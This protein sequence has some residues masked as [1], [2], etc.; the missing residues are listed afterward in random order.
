[1]WFAVVFWDRF[2]ATGVTSAAQVAS[3]RGIPAGGVPLFCDDGTVERTAGATVG[4]VGVVMVGVPVVGLVVVGVVV[5]PGGDV[6]EGD[7]DPAFLISA[8]AAEVAHLRPQAFVASTDIWI[9]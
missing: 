1:V 2:S 8:V 7:G 6:G 9:R 3:D 5:V 4:G